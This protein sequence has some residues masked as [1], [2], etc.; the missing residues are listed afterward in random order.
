MGSS[1]TVELAVRLET[2]LPPT[3]VCQCQGK[4][5][6][7]QKLKVFARY[8]G[9][10]GAYGGRVVVRTDHPRVEVRVASQHVPSTAHVRTD[11]DLHSIHSLVAG[12]NIEQ[13]VSRVGFARVQFV[14][15]ERGCASR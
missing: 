5:Y 13:R 9:K 10:L 11:L 6:V 3:P 12:Q 2:K 1:G 7:L 14:G 8:V 15:S 4:R